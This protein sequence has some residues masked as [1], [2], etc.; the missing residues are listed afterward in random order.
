MCLFYLIVA[1]ILVFLAI[2]GVFIVKVLLPLAV[3]GL[4]IAGIVA[5]VNETT[6]W[7]END[8]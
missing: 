1:P 6:D 2:A 3:L 4:I 7:L 8:T 5:I